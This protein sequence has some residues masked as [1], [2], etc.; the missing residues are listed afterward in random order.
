MVITTPSKQAKPVLE[1][2]S[3]RLRLIDPAEILDHKRYYSPATLRRD[4]EAAGFRPEAVS[5]RR[6]ELGLNLVAVAKA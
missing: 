2:I 5:V 3:L 1:L 4:I 6:F